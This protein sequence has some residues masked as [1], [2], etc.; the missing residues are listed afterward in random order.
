MYLY[1]V[2]NG[3]S[4]LTLAT[5]VYLK[6]FRKVFIDDLYRIQ[7]VAIEIYICIGW[8]QPDMDHTGSYIS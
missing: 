6:P 5:Y 4:T 3:C 2:D 7:G 8:L 1:A